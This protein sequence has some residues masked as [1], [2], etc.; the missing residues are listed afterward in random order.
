MKSIKSVRRWFKTRRG[1]VVVGA[2][3]VV[4]LSVGTAA[5]IGHAGPSQPAKPAVAEQVTLLENGKKVTLKP[6][7]SDAAL[8][9]QVAAIAQKVNVAATDA[10]ITTEGGNYAISPSANGQQIDVAKAVKMIR[11]GAFAGR[12]TIKLPLVSVAPKVTAAS[13]QPQLQQLKAK[14][15][16]VAAAR[17]T[18]TSCADN[19]AG[20]QLVLVSLSQQHLWAC[21]GSS[22]VY[23]TAITSGAYLVGDA[24]PTGTYHIYAK[25]TNQVL[26]GCDERG[27]W[28]DPVQYWMPF[29][30][31][32]GFHDA[33]WQ[34]FAYGSSQYASD[35]SHGCVHLPAAAMAWLYGWAPVGTTVTIN[36]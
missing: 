2:A 24:T 7:A 36:A 3:V 4:V 22:Q 1:L 29:Y 28:N 14:Q 25:Q 12:T 16:A 6:A 11:A 31:D 23:D 30:S 26:R 21:N 5:A 34:T 8:T 35:G 17:A 33:S 13:L 18:P 9:K 15:A 32:Y 20:R 10:K 19:P 27:C